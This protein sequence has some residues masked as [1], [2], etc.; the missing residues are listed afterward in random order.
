MLRQQLLLRAQLV[1]RQLLGAVAQRVL[2][3]VDGVPVLLRVLHQPQPVQPPV[4][5]LGV[6]RQA[7]LA[8]RHAADVAVREERVARAHLVVVRG[9]DG[10]QLLLGV[11]KH[12]CAVA[13][14]HLHGTQRLRVHLRLPQQRRALRRQLL[15]QL[16]LRQRQLAQRHARHALRQERVVR[17]HLLR[18]AQLRRRHLG[19]AARQRLLRGAQRL[20]AGLRAPAQVHQ[21]VRQTAELGVCDQLG[22]RQWHTRRRLLRQEREALVQVGLLHRLALRR[23]RLVVCQQLGQVVHRLLQPPRLRPLRRHRALGQLL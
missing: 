22:L 2:D 4:H 11:R 20:R 21:L 12:R 6:L 1:P 19:S 14:L 7:Q 9:V 23:R 16:V 15:E 5:V 13:Q 17:L 18:R 10:V 3:G 8:Q